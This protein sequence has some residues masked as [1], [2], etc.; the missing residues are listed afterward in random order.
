MGY[1]S[2]L[3]IEY[4]VLFPRTHTRKSDPS[5][6]VEQISSEAVPASEPKRGV[7]IHF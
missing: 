5:R 6:S 4:D 1:G 7:G 2:K 3:G